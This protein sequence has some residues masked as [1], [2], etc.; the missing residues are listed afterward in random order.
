MASLRE[1]LQE[2]E[3]WKA[4]VLEGRNVLSD[5]VVRTSVDR[6]LRR[7]DGSASETDNW[8]EDARCAVQGLADKD[9]ISLIYRH[10]EGVAREEAKLYPEH[11]RDTPNKLFKILS[12]AFGEKRSSAQLKRLIY[13]RSQRRHESIRSYSRALLDLVQKL[14]SD[15][16]KDSMLCEVFSN[17]VFDKY[18]RIELKRKLRA[19]PGMSFIALREF[20]LL[21]SE[22]EE[23]QC[24][25]S[26][27]SEVCHV[28][29]GAT[30]VDT[31][32]VESAVLNRLEAQMSEISRIQLQMA[33]IL[34][35]IASG[36]VSSSNHESPTFSTGY[37]Y[38][39]NPGSRSSRGAPSGRPVLSTVQCHFCKR[40][41]HYKRDCF[42]LHGR[43]FPSS[44][45]R[46]HQPPSSGSDVADVPD[47][48]HRS[49]VEA[50]FATRPSAGNSDG[51][52]AENHQVP[53]C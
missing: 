24:R 34:E 6:K 3:A 23:E 1:K 15:V 44:G 45:D 18:L 28:Q 27:K 25:T 20:A 42:K 14:D 11:E 46:F 12:D 36:P 35:K 50:P 53:L 21:I 51:H 41:G 47:R 19:S 17:N 22:E 16:E 13:E 33:G 48:D 10:L 2:L 5:I 39:A 38:G 26:V 9:A 8:I 52:Q 32:T 49:S 43:R 31:P 40:F 37:Q 29:S 4:G 30:P 7:F